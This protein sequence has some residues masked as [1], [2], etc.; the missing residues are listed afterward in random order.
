MEMK[1]IINKWSINGGVAILLTGL[2]IS[3]TK[4]KLSGQHNW[5]HVG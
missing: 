2:Q 1:S 3:R 4:N 5:L